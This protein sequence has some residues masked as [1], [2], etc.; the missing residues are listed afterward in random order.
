MFFL[1]Q[2]VATISPA[3]FQVLE[4]GKSSNITCS[5]S[6]DT[7][8]TSD[9]IYSWMLNDELISS[10]TNNWLAVDYHTLNAVQ[11]G[12]VYK[13]VVSSN[14]GKFSGQSKGLAILMA[15]YLI[16]QPENTYTRYMDSVELKC[17]ATGHPTP[18]IKWYKL[19][20]TDNFTNFSSVLENAHSLPDSSY[21]NNSA[22]NT[23]ET[24]TLVISSVEHDDFG[25]YICVASF[26][27][28]TVVFVQNCCSNDDISESP[29][30]S[31]HH[32]LSRLAVITGIHS[33]S[34]FN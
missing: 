18:V 3:N 23:T 34:V 13:C 21:Y 28:S 14:D 4:F 29:L 19:N 30:F 32:T 8:S 27:N 10:Q 12:G 11:L 31:S 6:A 33:I 17:T 22:T 26:D 20:S 9:F 7:V 16:E 15:P 25:Y 24:S 5:A 1:D 2:L